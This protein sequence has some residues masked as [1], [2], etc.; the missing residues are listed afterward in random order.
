MSFREKTAWIGIISLLGIIAWHFWPFL[1]HG[2]HGGGL[3]LAPLAIVA[4]VTVMVQLLVRLAVAAFSPKEAKAPP[5]EREK[6]IEL[7]G[8][9]FSYGVL[10]WGVRLALLLGISNPSLFFNA[11][12]LLFFLM[13]SEVRG[14]G[15]QIVQFRW[16]A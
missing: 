2:Q 10:G 8:R 4:A 12:T 7:N 5:E 13:I 9:R 16:G 11:N 6:L 1:H 3:A 14:V 15:Y